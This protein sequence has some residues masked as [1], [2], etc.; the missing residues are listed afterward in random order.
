[1]AVQ[2]FKL[3]AALDIFTDQLKEYA[4]AR[5]YKKVSARYD[6]Y[7]VKNFH[8]RAKMQALGRRNKK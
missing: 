5:A 4:V 6:R 2:N 3:L 1:M 8:L 7:K